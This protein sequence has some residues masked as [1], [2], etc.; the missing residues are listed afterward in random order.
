MPKTLNMLV[1][2]AAMSSIGFAA[3]AQDATKPA[4]EVTAV[5]EDVTEETAAVPE[6]EAIDAVVFAGDIKKG[7]KVFKKCKACHSVKAGKNGAGPSLHGI[8]GAQAAVVEG[9]RYSKAM[10]ESGVVWDA[11][12]LAAFLTKPKVF[13][14]GTKMSF[15]GLKKE[16]DVENL[17]AYL[18]DATQ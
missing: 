4:E 11:D 7:K 14:K 9:F 6:D 10:K 16:T 5:T 3:V 17:L 2:I 13:M 8:I 18:A 15:G 12:S 1:A